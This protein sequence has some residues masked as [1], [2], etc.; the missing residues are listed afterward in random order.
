MEPLVAEL[1]A[2]L[3]PIPQGGDVFLAPATDLGWG[4]I[5]G[6]Q[7]LAQ[8]LAA[9]ALTVPP[10]LVAH[11][12]H[13][14]F[15]APGAVNV[16]S[17]LEVERTRDGRSFASRRVVVRQEEVI[18]CLSASFQREQPGP[19]HQDAPMPVVAGPEA[20]QPD[21]VVARGWAEA[22]PE[23]LR[24]RA[25]AD[26][27]IEMRLIDPIHPL[28]PEKTPPVRRGWYRVRGVLPDAL[29]LHQTLLLYASDFHFLGTALQPHGVSWLTPGVRIA[30]LDHAMWFHRPFRFDQW[31]LFDMASPT[32]SGGRGFVTGRFFDQAGRLVA[33]VAQE[34]MLRG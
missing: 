24:A 14:S 21:T 6:G 19:E 5:F 15:L 18:F 23:P 27:P 33:S 8:A 2:S 3:R 34:G 11:S 31:L 9:A 28:K 22:L 29:S 12:V 30:S 17:R 4:R 25:T 10:E 1:I 13:A 26:R 16:Q 20:L 7:I 32:A